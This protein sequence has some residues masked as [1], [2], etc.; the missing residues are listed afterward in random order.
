[1]GNN[2][3]KNCKRLRFANEPFYQQAGLVSVGDSLFEGCEDLV[4]VEM[5]FYKCYSLE[6]IG[7]NIFKGCTKL[8]KYWDFCYETYLVNFPDKMFYDLKYYDYLK[9]ISNYNSFNG[10]WEVLREQDGQ[11]IA[12]DNSLSAF[13]KYK[14]YNHNNFPIRKH[15]KDLFSKEYLTDCISHG[16]AIFNARANGIFESIIS[17]EKYKSN[18][19][20]DAYIISNFTGEAFP[21]WE[22]PNFQLLFEGLNSSNYTYGIRNI[23]IQ[24]I[25]KNENVVGGNEYGTTINYYDNYADIADVDPIICGKY[26]NGAYHYV[27]SKIGLLDTYYSPIEYDNDTETYKVLECNDP[28][29]YVYE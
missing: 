21:V 23:K 20:Y 25:Y 4:S 26:F 27:R 6:K 16:D 8:R 12:D 10:Y 28:I 11:L 14:G 2:I 9:G 29:E 17:I 5:C 3:F 18:N 7:D 15:S 24:Y 19:C 1:M 22:I 13:F